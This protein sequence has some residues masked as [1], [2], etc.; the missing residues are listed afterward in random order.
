MTTSRADF[1]IFQRSKQKFDAALQLIQPQFKH[2]SFMEG[3]Q[4]LADKLSFPLE[5]FSSDDFII[6]E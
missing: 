6:L 4:R 1:P 5:G 2:I 3:D